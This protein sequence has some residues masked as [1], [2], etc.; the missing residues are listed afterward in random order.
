SAGRHPFAAR[1]SSELIW[2]QASAPPPALSSFR[3]EITSELDDLVGRCLAKKPEN[4]YA[5]AR[6]PPRALAPV[7]PVPGDEDYPSTRTL[8]VNP[9]LWVGT[10]L[11][12]RYE[13]HEWIAPGRVR[14]HVSRDTAPPRGGNGHV[15][16]VRAG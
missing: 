16:G 10:I 3:P 5:N 1:S 13:L 9:S 7:R 14:S 4:R 2:L 12:D 6:A 8:H 15:R 11:D